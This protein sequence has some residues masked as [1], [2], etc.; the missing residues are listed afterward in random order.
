MSK[1]SYNS[2]HFYD[3]KITKD[4]RLWW[5]VKNKH[6]TVFPFS[7]VFRSP[8]PIVVHMLVF[9]PSPLHPH[10]ERSLLPFSPFLFLEYQV[11]ESEGWKAARK[12]VREEEAPTGRTEGQH[13][14]SSGAPPLKTPRERDLGLKVCLQV[15]C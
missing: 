9:S 8:L 10:P 3:V 6:C 7:L 12:G 4:F 13:F 11:E 14:R 5:S 1:Q 15:N 2:I